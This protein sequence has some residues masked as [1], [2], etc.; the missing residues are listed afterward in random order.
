MP[1]YIDTKNQFRIKTRMEG[2]SLQ[3]PLKSRPLAENKFGG[4]V[5]GFSRLAS[6]LWDV[7]LIRDSDKVV[8]SLD[9]FFFYRTI[10]GI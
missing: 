10:D 1:V 9:I 6:H 8:L 3:G 2:F 7:G 5:E 4:G